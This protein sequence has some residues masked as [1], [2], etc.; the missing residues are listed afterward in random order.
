MKQLKFHNLADL[1]PLMDGE[2]FA[3][4]SA[5]IKA[6]GLLQPIIMYQGRVLDGRN[7]Y[8][9]CIEH[10]IAIS[11]DSYDGG[12]PLGFV[13]ASN[14]HR[15]HLSV[16]QRAMIGAKIANLAVGSNQYVHRITHDNETGSEFSPPLKIAAA[17]VGVN[18]ESLKQA[19][20]VRSSGTPELVKAVE[21]GAIVV[22]VASKVAKL[23]NEQQRAAVAEPKR[24]KHIVKRIHRANREAELAGKTAE[25]SR[26][27]GKT[28]YGVI[29]ADPPWKFEPYSQDTGMDRA[30]D[31]HYP[32]E[33]IDRLK[34][35]KLPAAKD[36]VL[37]LWATVPMLD[38]AIDVLRTWGFTYKSNFVWIKDKAGT[39]YWNRNR[40][41]ILLIATRGKPAAPAP[42][43]QWDSVFHE[44]VGKHSMKP[45]IFAEVIEKMFPTSKLLEMYARGPR[46]GWDTWGNEA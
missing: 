29:Y 19:R 6:N 16:S 9:A 43:D 21:Q 1:F 24:A 39:G 25:A 17:S 14:L 32:T 22:S 27:L 23:S 26:Q 28:V 15:R 8:R 4:F 40:H 33:D 2:E 7:R 5:D 35:L 3:A 42:G 30:A 31:N 38:V 13:I 46:A 20:A 10:D 44:H 45:A 36:C 18:V 34:A 41:E 37:F 12:D 11:V